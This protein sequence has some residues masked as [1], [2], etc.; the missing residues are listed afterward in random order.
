MA[1]FDELEKEMRKL[2]I[3]HSLRVLPGAWIVLRVDGRGFSKF[4]QNRFKKPFDPLFHQAMVEAAQ[5]LLVEFHGLYAYTESDEISLLLP[6]ECGLFDREVEKLVSVSSGLISASLSLAFQDLAHCDSRVWVGVSDQQVSSYFR[7]RHSDAGRCCLN[8]WCYWTLRQ[9]GASVKEATSRLQG[10]SFSQKNE[11]L[12]QHGINYNE[13]P[14]WQRRGTGLYWKSVSKPGLNPLTGE[15]TVT[16]RRKVYCD[17]ELPMGEA[18]GSFIG[19][20]L[21]I[22]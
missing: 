17:R 16:E 8:G 12:F 20:L 1:N 18:Y 22:P 4:T 13:V 2:E 10:L 14:L 5:R 19:H 11:L 15:K 21:S 6:R 7:W 9:A 3:F